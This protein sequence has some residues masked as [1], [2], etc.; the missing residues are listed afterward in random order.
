MEWE[1]AAAV[2][3]NCLCSIAAILWAVWFVILPPQRSDA[4]DE[5]GGQRFELG[6]ILFSPLDHS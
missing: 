1:E 6:Q 4:H 5:I 3:V 2:L